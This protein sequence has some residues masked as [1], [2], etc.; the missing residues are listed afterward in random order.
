VSFNRDGHWT[1][2]RHLEHGINTAASEG[3]STMSQD[4]KW[5]YFTSERSPFEVPTKQNLTTASW[6]DRQRAIENGVGNIYRVPIEALE[7]NR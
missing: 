2:A 1:Q 4:G 5:F 7:P 6:T 3:T